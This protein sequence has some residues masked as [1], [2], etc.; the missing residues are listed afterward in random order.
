MDV[1]E[2]GGS[3]VFVV[4]EVATLSEPLQAVPTRARATGIHMATRR[5]VRVFLIMTASVL[6]ECCE[7]RLKS[8]SWFPSWSR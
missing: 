7:D 8:G 6:V 5:V 3:D 1:D 2:A 4:P